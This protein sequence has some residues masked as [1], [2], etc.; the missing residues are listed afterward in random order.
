MFT[1][2]NG[3]M[4]EQKEV[5]LRGLVWKLKDA[6]VELTLT[7][8]TLANIIM[9][10]P[11][12]AG[13]FSV[14]FPHYAKKEIY[15]GPFQTKGCDL[16]HTLYPERTHGKIRSSG[17]SMSKD[18]LSLIRFEDDF[19]YYVRRNGELDLNFESMIVMFSLPDY[20]CMPV[21]EKDLSE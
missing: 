4:N 21:G 20:N 12:L 15:I 19:R 16:E 11:N 10:V 14:E 7:G 8:S 3:G 6:G 2:I 5:F 18:G 17:D 13:S 9:E 1:V